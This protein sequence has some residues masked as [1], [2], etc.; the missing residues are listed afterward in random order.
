ME[1]L[2]KNKIERITKD[3]VLQKLENNGVCLGP[4]DQ[5]LDDL[6]CFYKNNPE[7]LLRK[8]H[9]LQ[10]EDNITSGIETLTDLDIYYSETVGIPIVKETL[11]KT[12]VFG[13][14][15]TETY[16]YYT[17]KNNMLCEIDINDL[18]I[19]KN[20]NALYRFSEPKTKKFFDISN[21]EKYDIV[22]LYIKSNYE[23]YTMLD[24]AIVS[25]CTDTYIIQLFPAEIIKLD[26][27]KKDYCDLLNQA[28]NDKTFMSEYNKLKTDN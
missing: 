3:Y 11:T 27:S 25:L 15:K 1:I 21:L 12:E 14:V 20:Y 13:D 5:I 23:P 26:K 18:Q 16:K 7:K 19:N 28:H 24:N 10:D 6:L 8:Y 2:S 4:L 22:A 17:Y 9:I